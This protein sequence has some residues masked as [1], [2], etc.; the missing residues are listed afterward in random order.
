M[1]AA[2]CPT[3]RTRAVPTSEPRASAAPARTRC[4]IRASDWSA[5]YEE[6]QRRRKDEAPRWKSR[7][8][9]RLKELGVA[10]VEVEYDGGG[11]EG[12]MES[13]T[14]YKDEIEIAID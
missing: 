9:N 8:I 6:E 13:L 1:T 10:R 11:D 7:I 5:R 3:R 4:A 12:C 14:A 2:R